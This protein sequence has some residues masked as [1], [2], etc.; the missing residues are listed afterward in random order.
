M[1]QD[2]TR[3]IA[4]I[5]HESVRAYREELSHEES[6]DP[7]DL[8][9]RDQQAQMEAIVLEVLQPGSVP[10]PN[11]LEDRIVSAVVTAAHGAL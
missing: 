3:L 8:L 11:N 5:A 4:R 7:W 6:L 1:T 10:D 2:E 9:D